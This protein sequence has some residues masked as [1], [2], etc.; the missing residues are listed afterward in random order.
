MQLLQDC[1]TGNPK[2]WAE[3]AESNVPLIN[4]DPN[5]HDTFLNYQFTG[6]FRNQ[7][8]LVVLQSKFTET[9]FEDLDSIYAKIK[10]RQ[11]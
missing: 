3:F 10:A 5:N 6:N 11:I 7:G 8:R 1:V 9:L 2:L 4:T